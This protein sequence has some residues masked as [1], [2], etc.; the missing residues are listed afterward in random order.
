MVI[1]YT[2]YQTMLKTLENNEIKNLSNVGLTFFD[3][4]DSD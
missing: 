3:V 2:L 4:L 1:E